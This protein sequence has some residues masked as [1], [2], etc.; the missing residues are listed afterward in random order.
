MIDAVVNGTD[1]HATP[2]PVS[3][4]MSGQ[5]VAVTS[6]DTDVDPDDL[7]NQMSLID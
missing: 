6:D 1:W 7:S 2:L 4:D 5:N 3:T